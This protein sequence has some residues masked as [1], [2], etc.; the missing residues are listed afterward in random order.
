MRQADRPHATV[1]DFDARQFVDLVRENSP[2]LEP[3]IAVRILEDDDPVPLLGVE[4]AGS[5]TSPAVVLSNPQPPALVRRHGDR[6]LNSGS[7]ATTDN[8]KPG[9]SLAVFTTS[10][11]AIGDD[12]AFSVFLESEIRRPGKIPRRQ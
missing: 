6:V 4:S 8:S 3:A 2:L 7:A 11:G 10:S 9:G 1:A 12:V 5:C